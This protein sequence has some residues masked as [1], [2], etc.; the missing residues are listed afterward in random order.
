M[1]NSMFATWRSLL[2]CVLICLS[3]LTGF[4]QSVSTP[5][6]SQNGF[7]LKKTTTNT[8]IQTG[9]N[10][11]YNIDFTIP[12]GATNVVITDI[13][14][15]P[16]TY[17][18]ITFTAPCGAPPSVITPTIG[19][20]G[21][22]SLTFASVPA[23]CTGSLSITVQFPNGT[24][25][26]GA[27]VGNKACLTG[28]VG[29][30]GAQFCTESVS[31]TAQ[32]INPWHIN[33][34]LLS[35]SPT[36]SCSNSIT[37]DTA[38][39]QFCV[40]KNVG[41]TG[42]LNLLNGTVT[43]VLPAGAVILSSS[44]P[45]TVATVGTQ[46][47]VT[48]NLGAVL[49]ATPQYNQ[50][51]CDFRVHYPTSS[52]PSGTPITNTAT[53]SG[54]LGSPTPQPCGTF[55]QAS[56]TTSYQIT[57]VPKS[58]LYK[59]VNTTGQPGCGG[60]YTIYVCNDGGVTLNTF[61]ITDNLPTTLTGYTVVSNTANVSVSISGGVLTGTSTTSLPP[62]GYVSITVDFTIPLT[63]T[64][65]SITNCVT[66]ASPQL[67]SAVQACAPFFITAPLP[68]ACVWK[69]VCSKQT[70]YLPGS[71]LRYRLRV[72]N[73]GGLA[74]TG[75][76]VT[77]LLPPYLSLAPT[78]NM[79]YY[80]ANTWNIA[81]ASPALPTG[82]TAWTGVNYTGS[83]QNLTWN[84]P[85]IAAVC[86]SLFYTGCGQ[87]GTSNVPYY[88]IEFDVRVNDDAPIGVVPNN[89]TINGGNLPVAETSNTD[90]INIVGSA[91][92]N[93]VKTITSPTTTTVAPNAI[94]TYR[95]Q[96]NALGTAALRHVVMADLL[97]RNNGASDRRLLTTC[98]PRG[99][100][101]SLTVPALSTV[102][103]WVGLPAA[104]NFTE[105][106]E[107]LNSADVNLSN[108][109]PSGVSGPYFASSCGAFTT[110][111]WTTGAIN[112]IPAGK[113]NVGY[114]FGI[115]AVPTTSYAR[116]D[117]KAQVP[118][119][120][121]NG[122]IAC[123]SF[124][125][126]AAKRYLINSTTLQDIAMTEQ[127]SPNVCIT[128]K[129][130][131]IVHQD[132]CNDKLIQPIINGTCCEYSATLQNLSGSPIT[133]ILWTA[134]TG[135]IQG[136]SA[137]GCLSSVSVNSSTTGSIT[138]S[139]ACASNPLL[140]FSGTGNGSG[141]VAMTLTIIHQN[142]DTCRVRF[143]YLCK[144]PI[145]NR[146]DSVSV[147]PFVYPGLDASGRTFTV[148]NLKIPNGPICWIDIKVGTLVGATFTQLP[149]WLGGGMV[150]PNVLAPNNTA[151]FQSIAGSYT[152]LPS[153]QPNVN[154]PSNQTVS[155]NL[156]VDYTYIN[157]GNVVVRLVVHHCDGDSCSYEIKWQKP[158]THCP[159]CPILDATAYTERIFAKQIA[160]KGNGDARPVKYVAFKIPSNSEAEIFA[161]S[162]ESMDT[163]GSSTR[164]LAQ[165]KTA[166]MSSK[167]ALFEFSTPVSLG[168][169]QK[170]PL[171]NMVFAKAVPNLTYTLFDEN[172]NE[173]STQSVQL[174]T[175]L[176]GT[177]QA[178]DGLKAKVFPNPAQSE[179]FVQYELPQ[180]GD[181]KID[182]FNANGQ[183]IR[184]LDNSRQE[185][186]AYQ[187][188]FNTEGVAKGAYFIRIVSNGFTKSLPLMIQ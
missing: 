103:A 126:N 48:W 10:F 166:S 44:C 1:K 134:T 184:N 175:G 63:A 176:I 3:S 139:P 60:R 22:V 108:I 149:W 106:S 94:L 96:F 25:C 152:R 80:T 49:L 123:N 145:A 35:N 147:K 113:K 7:I 76:T 93:L 138:F 39:Y 112:T 170:S 143:E 110:A 163:E 6:A 114:Y 130:D 86:Q 173:L 128:V 82:A 51:C 102:G 78:P 117:F 88:Y 133:Q 85:S 34:Y 64:G 29:P 71:I 178:T 100:N 144:N 17:Q 160:L 38:R 9:V 118:A 53:L 90:Y 19:T 153:N 109:V 156:G 158:V 168:L 8:T 146:C 12:A 62:G 13:L 75:T 95:L 142:G 120:A 183:F 54:G 180:T 46:Q 72:Q 171:I 132:T 169:N 105:G 24:T 121:T 65:P 5:V 15:A 167:T 68:K 92:Y 187:T 179:A 56:N 99:S 66:L 4:A 33:K 157:T 161:T 73:I 107:T 185:S 182:L 151:L 77:D 116:V 87:Y 172:G 135:T 55:T 57:T 23:G 61:T 42:Q 27:V 67:L 186:G 79:V 43:D 150:L 20:N 2:C 91:G 30:L 136:A 97:P 137:T 111:V 83:G 52:F 129:Q 122:Q 28:K 124:A 58:K 127:E 125:S 162:A 18:A 69:E 89:F 181:V 177:P 104:T 16:L 26:N 174:T 98:A 140:S 74:M 36:G 41:T 148:H 21:T 154:V 165:L 47:T 31:T 11:S 59:W 141:L 84:L 119:T 70:S 155:F 131:T 81:C 188:R 14:P 37:N 45:Y 40:W 159:T 164:G 115:Q 32:A 101:F 50:V